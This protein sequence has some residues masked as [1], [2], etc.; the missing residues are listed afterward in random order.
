MDP[1]SGVEPERSDAFDRPA[2]VSVVAALENVCV[3]E[4]EIEPERN[5]VEVLHDDSQPERHDRPVSHN[6]DEGIGNFSESR[7]EPCGR[8]VLVLPT[9]DFGSTKVPDRVRLVVGS[10]RVPRLADLPEPT[11]DRG[12]GLCDLDGGLNRLTFAARDD[13]AQRG[14]VSR[15]QKLSKGACAETSGS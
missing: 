3:R 4:A 12:R 1:R 8:L 6:G 5:R 11:V 10:I 14:R 13:C 2:K 9:G 7:A 15:G